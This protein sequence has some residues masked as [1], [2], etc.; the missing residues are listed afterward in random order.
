M[1]RLTEKQLFILISLGLAFL[2][3]VLYGCIIRHDF[4]NYYDD[5]TYTIPT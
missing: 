5:A 2:T 3:A 4:V 1:A